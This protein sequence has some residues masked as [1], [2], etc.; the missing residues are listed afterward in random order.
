MNETLIV[1]C[2]AFRVGLKFAVETQ[3]L[4]DGGHFVSE[5]AGADAGQ[6]GAAERGVAAGGTSD[7]RVKEIADDAAP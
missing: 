3:T 7:W 5:D 4:F 6:Q 1:E 2:C